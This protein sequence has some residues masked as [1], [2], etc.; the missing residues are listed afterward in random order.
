[1]LPSPLKSPTTSEVRK[2]GTFVQD[3]RS[4]VYQIE[5]LVAFRPARSS[6]PSP[7]KSPTTSEVRKPGTFVQDTRS[8]VY[9]IEPLVAFRPASS[10]WG[11]PTT[12]FG[13]EPSGGKPG[14]SLENNSELRC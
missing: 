11:A 12:S 1:A 2:P 5:P 10:S 6:W 3:T 13:G 14:W 7:L 9:Q 4:A 8:A